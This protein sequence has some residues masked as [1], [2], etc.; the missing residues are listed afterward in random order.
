MINCYLTGIYNPEEK[1]TA[2]RDN[3]KNTFNEFYLTRTLNIVETKF[4]EA[5]QK[6]RDCIQ[7]HHEKVASLA[8]SNILGCIGG[9]NQRL[10][11]I[12]DKVDSLINEQLL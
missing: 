10:N 11:L 5:E 9:F 8:S 12:R 1:I 6:L 4:E 7:G 3:F 2:V